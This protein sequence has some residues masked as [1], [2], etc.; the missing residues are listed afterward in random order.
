[1][2]IVNNISPINAGPDLTLCNNTPSFRLNTTPAYTKGISWAIIPSCFSCFSGSTNNPFFTAG[3]TSGINHKLIA[4][5]LN[6]EGCASRDT[7]SVKIA[8]PFI[9]DFTASVTS[10]PAPLLVNFANNSSLTNGF[11]YWDFGDTTQGSAN[12]SNLKNPSRWYTKAGSYTIKLISN[13]TTFGINCYDTLTK[14]NFVTVNPGMYAASPAFNPIRIFPNPTQ[15]LVTV[16]CAYHNKYLV[17]L[18]DYTGKMALQE[19]FTGKSSTLHIEGLAK[20]IY[21]VVITAENNQRT[22]IKLVKE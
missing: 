5:Y 7:I 4:T 13:D 16:Q 11:W 2:I 15:N 9:A 21:L 22:T 6:V 12:F 18:F 3:Q 14:F 10:G 17:E 19:T 1:M 8:P 20:G